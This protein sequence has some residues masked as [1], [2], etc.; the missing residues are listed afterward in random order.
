[1]GHLSLACYQGYWNLCFCSEASL[2]D[3]MSQMSA[4]GGRGS[5]EGFYPIESLLFTPKHSLLMSHLLWEKL[6]IIHKKCAISLES[7]HWGFRAAM[8]VRKTMYYQGRL[9]KN[10]RVE[11]VNLTLSIMAVSRG[12]KKYRAFWSQ[13]QGSTV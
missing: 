6:T 2:T 3:H 11:E 8:T 1:L 5:E 4:E 12:L 9:D 7:S 10:Y 13:N